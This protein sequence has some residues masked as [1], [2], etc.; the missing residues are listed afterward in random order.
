MEDI[1]SDAPSGM[2]VQELEAKVTV[3]EYD[4]AAEEM[5][6]NPEYPGMGDM[7][8]LSTNRCKEDFHH[9]R[10]WGAIHCGVHAVIPD[11]RVGATIMSRVT[12]EHGRKK[13]I[14]ATKDEREDGKVKKEWEYLDLDVGI[15]RVA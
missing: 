7:L 6:R 3:G 12:G 15:E 13:L 2:T 4:E 11:F 10:R 5:R 1:W 9:E 14:P 8:Y